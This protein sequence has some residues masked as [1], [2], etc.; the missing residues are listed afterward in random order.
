MTAASTSGRLEPPAVPAVVLVTAAEQEVYLRRMASPRDSRN[1][2]PLGTVTT[3]EWML[4]YRRRRR[5]P[6]CGAG[7]LQGVC[8]YA[9]TSPGTQEVPPPVGRPPSRLLSA[10]GS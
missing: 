9:I 10:V 5:K 3:I 6:R 4:G 7:S 8:D 1:E 2:P